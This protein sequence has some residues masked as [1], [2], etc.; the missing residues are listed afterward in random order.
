MDN[1]D[2]GSRQN[3]EYLSAN[4]RSE[5]MRHDIARPLYVEVDEI[6]NTVYSPHPF[7]THS[8]RSKRLQPV[9]GAPAMCW[10]R[11]TASVL[12]TRAT[13]GRSEQRQPVIIA[14]AREKLNRPPRSNSQD[15]LTR[16]IDYLKSIA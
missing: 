5:V 9:F 12:L 4:R 6:C 14:L 15:G 13:Q 2:N 7:T 8:I 10:A 16:T 3:I 11:L 1:C